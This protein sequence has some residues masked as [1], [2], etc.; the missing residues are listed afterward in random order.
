MHCHSMMNSIR[1]TASPTPN[2]LYLPPLEL[3]DYLLQCFRQIG[4]S[5]TQDDGHRRQSTPHSWR[6]RTTAL[7]TVARRKHTST[8]W[9]RRWRPHSRQ[10]TAP[11]SKRGKETPCSRILTLLSSYPDMVADATTT[12]V[13]LCCNSNSLR[14]CHAR[15]RPPRRPQLPGPHLKRTDNKV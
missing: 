9:R 12:V 13:R 11:R 3:Y 8:H 1:T 7:T 14:P 5:Y 6:R 2:K 15:P 4:R 10:Q